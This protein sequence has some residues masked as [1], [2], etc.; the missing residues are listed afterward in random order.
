MKLS[1]ERNQKALQTV[2]RNIYTSGIRERGRKVPDSFPYFTICLG[3]DNL[4][5]TIKT[6]IGV[7]VFGLILVV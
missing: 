6:N 4:I 3:L 7:F 1:G 2:G 5:L